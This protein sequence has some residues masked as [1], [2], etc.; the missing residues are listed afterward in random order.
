MRPVHLNVACVSPS[1]LPPDAICELDAHIFVDL[2]DPFL[3]QTAERQR[4]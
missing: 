1:Y 4:Q 3:C 2:T